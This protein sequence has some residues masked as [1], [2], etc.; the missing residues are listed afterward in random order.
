[1]YFNSEQTDMYPKIRQ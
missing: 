1:M